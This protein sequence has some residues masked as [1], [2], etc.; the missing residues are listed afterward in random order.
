MCRSSHR[1]YS[2]KKVFLEISQNS[3]E[4]TCVRDSFLIKLQASLAQVFSCEFCE[5][6][7]NSFFTEHIWATA[8]ECEK[9]LLQNISTISSV[10]AWYRFTVNI[11][12]Y[13]G[14]FNKTFLLKDETM[15]V[16]MFYTT[17]LYAQAFKVKHWKHLKKITVL[18][19]SLKIT[20]EVTQKF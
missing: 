19:S 17:H 8:S 9:D 14:C 2:V 4:N 1:R 20:E 18:Q 3:Q 10:L 16:K 15:L 7:K 5:V 13:K 12:I 6:S 11:G